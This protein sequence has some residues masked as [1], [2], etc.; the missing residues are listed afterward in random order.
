MV[1]SEG[2]KMKSIAVK[3]VNKYEG[4]SKQCRNLVLEAMG[5]KPETFFFVDFKMLPEGMTTNCECGETIRNV[6]YFEN[7][8]GKIVKLGSTCAYRHV[9]AEEAQKLKEEIARIGRKK[10]LE[11]KQAIKLENARIREE[12]K[13]IAKAEKEKANT[14]AKNSISTKWDEM[15]FLIGQV[16]EIHNQYLEKGKRS[17][18]TVWK[19]A[20]CDYSFF[21]NYTNQV[22]KLRKVEEFI[23]DAKSVL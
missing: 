18:Y 13:Q 20:T 11:K 23:A 14:E 9:Q 19:I 22:N 2:K 21:D 6:S 8:Q 4:V 15:L 17:P 12:K 10:Y 3:K 1:I 7:A 5:N 16:K